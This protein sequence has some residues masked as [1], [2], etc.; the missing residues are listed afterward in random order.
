[1][2]DGAGGELPPAVSEVMRSGNLTGALNDSMR[3]PTAG[4]CPDCTEH[5]DQPTVMGRTASENLLLDNFKKL[6]GDPIAFAQAMCFL[7]THGRKSFQTTADG[8]TNGVRLEQQRYVTI[9]DLNKPS[10]EKRLFILDRQTGEVRAYHSGH[11]RGSGNRSNTHERITHFSNTGSSN[12]NPRGFF[13]TGN[14]YQSS[15]SFG[16]G[17][18]LHGLQRGIND[19]SMAR[20]IVI[21][22]AD[23]TPAGVARSSE[24]RPR[25]TG[26][27]S[28][29]SHGCTTV[30]NQHY[31]E[32]ERM[33]SSGREGR[34]TRGG[35]LYYNYSPAERSAGARYCGDNLLVR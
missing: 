12:T 30:A 6:G 7:N 31:R 4:Y 35:S 11:G 24:A 23:Y 21:H 25:L 29:R 18:R 5:R 34:D 9:N 28:G 10:S 33:L 32:I 8:Y 3:G 14:T 20:G 13:I 19:N 15:K 17:I 22:K 16:E 27:R 26:S 1:M 2:A